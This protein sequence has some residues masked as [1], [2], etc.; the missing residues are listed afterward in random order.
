[1]H[2]NGSGRD[3]QF[4]CNRFRGM[5]SQQELRYLPF[6]LRQCRFTK[7]LKALGQALVHAQI[8]LVIRMTRRPCIPDSLHGRP[9]DGLHSPQTCNIGSRKSRFPAPD[10]KDKRTVRAGI[11]NEVHFVREV[12]SFVVLAIVFTGPKAV[13]RFIA[14][15]THARLLLAQCQLIQ[16][17]EQVWAGQVTIQVV[18]GSTWRHGVVQH[19]RWRILIKGQQARCVV[20]NRFA[21]DV[22]QRIGR[23]LISPRFDQARYR[24]VPLRVVESSAQ[25]NPPTADTAPPSHRLDLR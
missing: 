2:H 12:R 9:D 1:M 13:R 19:V 8:T 15:T 22:Y 3:T 14:T 21:N 24:D 6:S 23:R 25:E 16:G 11:E 10:D 5:T 7:V 4:S 20:F 18:A 17:I